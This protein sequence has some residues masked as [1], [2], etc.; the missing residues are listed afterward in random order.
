MR[1]D[2]RAFLRRAAVTSAAAAF[3]R[4]LA[5]AR[6]PDSDGWREFEITTRVEVLKPSGKT[7]VWLPMPLAVAPYQRTLGD[8]YRAEGGIIEMIER[9]DEAVDTLVAEWP[10]GVTPLLK[11]TS[12]VATKDHAADL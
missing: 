4:R 5:L 7:R 8:T 9:P 11:V 6:Q 12:R 10:A 2:R 1:L 3:D